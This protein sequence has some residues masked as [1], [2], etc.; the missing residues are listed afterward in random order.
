MTQSLALCCRHHLLLGADGL[1]VPARS[2]GASTAVARG[3]GAGG[4]A[5]SAGAGRGGPLI[6]DKSSLSD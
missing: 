5:G 4:R 6:Q 3:G 1:E 2:A